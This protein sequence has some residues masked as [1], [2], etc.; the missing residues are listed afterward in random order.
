MGSF[1]SAKLSFCI[2]ACILEPLQ[3]R[4]TIPQSALDAVRQFYNYITGYR[5]LG[6]PHGPARKALETLM[7]KRL[8]R[9]L[10][11]LSECNDDYFRRYGEIL[12]AKTIKAAI[13]WGDEG[14]FTGLN[15]SATPS[16][17][18]ILGSRSIGE[19]RVDVLIAFKDDWGDSQGDVTAIRENS[20][21]VI[22]DYIAMYENDELHRLSAGYPEC[23]GGE[24]VGEPAY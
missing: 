14:L 17:F 23:K 24:W 15:D 5:Q 20:R 2:E 19:N 22:D 4:A 12:C 11:S 7:S 21:W 3:V 16:T 1:H 10:D 8:V 18:R 6:I 9:E 13:P